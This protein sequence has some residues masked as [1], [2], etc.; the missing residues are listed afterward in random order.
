MWREP[1]DDNSKLVAGRRQVV[2]RRL[3]SDCDDADDH[4]DHDHDDGDADYDARQCDDHYP[5]REEDG[6]GESDHGPLGCE[7]DGDACELG[8]GWEC[9]CRDD[10][11][12]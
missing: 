5:H 2:W 12:N 11:A 1:E 10:R 4:D 9:V 6:G 7:G 3:G 8:T